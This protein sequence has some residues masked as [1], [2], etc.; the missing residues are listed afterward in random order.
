MKPAELLA[1]GTLSKLADFYAEDYE[2]LGY[3][4]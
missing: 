3:T 4:P 2:F 1:P